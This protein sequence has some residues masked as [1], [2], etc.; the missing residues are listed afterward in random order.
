MIGLQCSSGL[1]DRRIP[2]S[3]RT[4]DTRRMNNNPNQP[5]LSSSSSSSSSSLTTSNI[6]L[7]NGFKQ[8]NYPSFQNNDRQL[9]ISPRMFQYLFLLH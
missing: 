7:I 9:P 1:N 6:R 8:Q 3:L 2:S 4:P 5:P